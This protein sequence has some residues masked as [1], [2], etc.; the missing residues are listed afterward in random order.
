MIDKDLGTVDLTVDEV[1]GGSRNGNASDDPLPRLLDVD[2]GAGFRHL[3]QRPEVKTL[4][5]LV[6]KTS[7]SDPNWPDALDDE[8]GTFTYYGDKRAPG[9]LHQTPRQGNLMPKE[10]LNKPPRFSSMAT[11]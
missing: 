8:S 4:K 11:I 1:Y 6:L 3:G 7:F 2:N 9:D 5:L 10:T